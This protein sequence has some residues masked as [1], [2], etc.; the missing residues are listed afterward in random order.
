ME[1]DKKKSYNILLCLITKNIPHELICILFNE[2]NIEKN[3]LVCGNIY[4]SNFIIQKEENMRINK[5]YIYSICNDICD[6]HY[7]IQ[8]ILKNN[9]HYEEKAF[10]DSYIYESMYYLTNDD[11]NNFYTLY[12]A[13]FDEFI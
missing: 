5:N 13:Y 8:Y 3:Y 10:L 9:I 4:C 12:P 1:T 2:W 11:K 6:I 7:T